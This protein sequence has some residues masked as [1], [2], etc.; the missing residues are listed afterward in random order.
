LLFTQRKEKRKE[1]LPL[2]YYT[3]SYTCLNKGVLRPHWEGVQT[4]LGRSS[5]TSLGRSSDLAGK[6]FSDLAGKEFSD[7][8]GKEF[9][10]LAGKE[11]RPR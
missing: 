3:K 5:Q 9:S 6:E 11:F 7:L 4:S 1:I 8:A 2:S 10:D